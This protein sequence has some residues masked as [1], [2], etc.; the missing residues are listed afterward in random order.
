MKR[1]VRSSMRLLAAPCSF[2]LVLGFLGLATVSGFGQS[3]A[4]Y[5]VTT[6]TTGSLALDA[7]GNTIDMTTGTT[8]ILTTN[9]SQ[10]QAINAAAITFGR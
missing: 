10:D 9:T 6:S 4:N 2:S 5:G 3:T 1:F 7:N 8:Q